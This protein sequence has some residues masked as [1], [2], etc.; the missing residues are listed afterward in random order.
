MEAF[1]KNISSVYC[2]PVNFKIAGDLF[3]TKQ[4]PLYFDNGLY[5]NVHNFLENPE[6][7]KINKK[8]GMFLTD[9]L[10]AK[11]IFKDY[12]NPL[13]VVDLEYITTPLLNNNL[14][15]VTLSA[16]GENK[17]FFNSQRQYFNNQDVFKI[18]FYENTVQVEAYDGSYL[19]YSGGTGENTVYFSSK[20]SPPAD[21]QR[22]DYLLSEDSI[23]LFSYN[24]YFSRVL[25]TY[26]SGRLGLSGIN[27]GVNTTFP[28]QTV[29]KFASYKNSK[30]DYNTVPNS[31]L[32]RYV[33]SPLLNQKELIPTPDSIN[34]AYRQNYLALFPVLNPTIENEVAEYNLQIHGLKNYQTPEYNYTRGS[35]Y[36]VES[37]SIRRL[38]RQIFSGTNQEEGTDKIYLGYTSNTFEKIFPEDE[39]TIFH[40]PA[41]APRAL[42]PYAGLIEDGA[43]SAEVPYV[44]DRIYEKQIDYQEI[45]PGQSQ[46]QSI[47]RQDGT[48]LCSWLYSSPTGPMWMDRYYNAA[49]Y[50][51]DQALSA[52]VF[53]Y[54]REIDPEVDSNV[55]D[56][57]TKMILEPGARYA[58]YRSGLQTSKNFLKYLDADFN[59]PLGA[60]IL[61][62]ENFNESVLRDSSNYKNNGLL[63]NN[64]SENLKGNYI[65]LDGSNHA[66][67]PA[68][69]ILL[70]KNSL[71]LSIWLNVEDWSNITGDQIIGNY[72]DSG[73][74]LLNESSLTAPI[75]T[76]LNAAS[77]VVYNLNY[78]L[79]QLD[80]I[81][82]PPLSGQQNNTIVRLPDF[83]YWIIDSYNRVLRKYSIEGNVK[84]QTTIPAVSTNYI[85][86]VEVDSKEN[87]YLFDASN[88][89]VIVLDTFG[90]PFSSFNISQTNAFKRIEIDLNDKLIPI[91]GNSSVIDNNNNV[92]EM[93]G[94][95]LYKNRE[96]YANIGPVQQITCD[97]KNNLWIVHAKDQLSKYNTN[98]RTFEFSKSIGKNVLIDDSCFTFNN[99]FRFANFMRVPK[100]GTGCTY[101]TDKTEDLLVL[102]DN[103]DKIAWLINS[104]GLLVNKINLNALVSNNL[105]KVDQNLQ[106][107]AMGDFSSYQYLRKYGITNKNFSWNFKIADTSGKN[108]QL[109]KLRYDISNLPSGWHN[110]VF[111]FDSQN[112][113]A[114]YYID[115]FLV[116]T[117][118]FD[119][120]KY[121]IYY[122]YNSSILLGAANVKNSTLNDVIKIDDAYKFIGNVGHI[123]MYAKPFTQGEVE[124]IYYSSPF[125]IDK[126]P[127]RWNVNTGER[128]YVEEIQHW[129]QMQ[130][131]SN[132]SKYFNLNIHNL[133]VSDEIKAVI[134]E[135]IR[136]N[137][138][139]ISPA[140]TELYKIN[141]VN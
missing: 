70:E 124:Q 104:D 83:S 62:V 84:Y 27:F 141:W 69:N 66:I 126:G 54:N 29:L 94:G 49:Y 25:T 116:S 60:K 46:P 107:M 37:N 55:W 103:S 115:T 52:S 32:V 34:E 119:K 128:N 56:E 92:W 17:Y 14:N 22:F 127:L 95:N 9:L 11:N 21:S 85:N 4:T 87:L 57:N 112:G 117:Q 86:Q 74:G 89:K 6:D 42:L 137:I 20:I 3:L 88:N 35:K 68:K 121:Q 99:Q 108:A 91:Y 59:K 61:D 26:N 132:K 76:L 2:Y 50:T 24:T 65:A 101:T 36:Y 100:T 5:F 45:T 120:N 72:Y 136:N 64:R 40:Y 105:S 122:D 79:S 23:I 12:Q 93:V 138:K 10:S 78:K 130:L 8:T 1:V 123:L 44:A 19:T 90:Q 106:F 118:V 97:S 39:F 139:K 16:V 80:N 82:L 28:V 51:S 7:V 41:T 71:T 73:F 15:T 98:T 111:M 81:N 13:D 135:A 67:F 77:G 125:S 38:Y 102:V 18:I 63:F 47:K 131:P 48:W 43:Y 109:L 129:F 110:F 33:S 75:F 133:N 31:Y 30:L 58:Y 114:K 96:V 113:V 134:E 53:L 140:H